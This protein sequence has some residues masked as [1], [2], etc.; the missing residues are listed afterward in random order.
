MGILLEIP[1]LIGILALGCFL[2]R[3]CARHRLDGPLVKGRDLAARADKQHEWYLAGDPRGIYGNFMPP[4]E[5]LPKGREH[6]PYCNIG[7]CYGTWGYDDVVT[8]PSTEPGQ[9]WHHH[10][11]G[12]YGA[13]INHQPIY[14]AEER[15]LD[16]EYAIPRRPPGASGQRKSQ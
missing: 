1:F 12:R 2:L 8:Y 11:E 6:P 13:I 7:K 3:C 16:G 10:T 15:T 5:F 9:P 14:L 4:P